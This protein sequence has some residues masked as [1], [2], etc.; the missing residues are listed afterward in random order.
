MDASRF[1]PPSTTLLGALASVPSSTTVPS[2]G[3]SLL[4]AAVSPP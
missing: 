2:M 4:I 1:K 3:T